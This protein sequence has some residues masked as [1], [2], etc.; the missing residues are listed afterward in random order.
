MRAIKG[1]L[2]ATANNQRT[3]KIVLLTS[4]L[5]EI[6][7]VLSLRKLFDI[8]AEGLAFEKNQSW[9]TA[10]PGPRQLSPWC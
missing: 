5:D 7:R 4:R 2:L 8:L 1:H 6:T 3:V 9:A 10:T